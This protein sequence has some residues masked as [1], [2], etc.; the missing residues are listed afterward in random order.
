M[1]AIGMKQGI[2]KTWLRPIRGFIR[3]TIDFLID[4][5]NQ[6]QLSETPLQ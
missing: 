3:C 2:N 1:V 6:G 5:Q 4:Y